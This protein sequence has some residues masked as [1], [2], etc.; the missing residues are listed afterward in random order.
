MR[1]TTLWILV[2][3]MEFPTMANPIVICYD[4]ATTYKKPRRPSNDRRG[5][6]EKC[7]MNFFAETPNL[8]VINQR[9]FHSI[10][11]LKSW[12]LFY[13]HSIVAGGFDEMS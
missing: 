12:V 10:L 4:I 2:E 1:L 6:H 9:F 13:S 7:C 3:F 8:G 5:Y 11:L